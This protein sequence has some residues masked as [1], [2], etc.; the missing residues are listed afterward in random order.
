VGRLLV[1]GFWGLLRKPNYLG[2][3][4]IAISFSLPSGGDYIF[5]YFY[6]IYLGILL[7]HRQY[8]DEQRCAAKYGEVWRE[9]CRRVPYVAIPGIL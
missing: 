4:L 6:P 8:R 1:T 5:A 2:D 7:A 3:F 9:Y